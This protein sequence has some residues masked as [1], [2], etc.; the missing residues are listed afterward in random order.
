[1]VPTPSTQAHLMPVCPADEV[2][3]LVDMLRFSHPDPSGVIRLLRHVEGTCRSEEKQEVLRI[4]GYAAHR[5]NPDDD[6]G[7]RWV[8]TVLGCSSALDN[9]M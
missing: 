5:F 8:P 3:R 2:T 4:R 6:E 9:C 1:M 7:L